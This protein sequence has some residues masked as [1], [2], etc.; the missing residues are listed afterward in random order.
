MQNNM[1]K[2]WQ[3]ASWLLCIKI[4]NFDSANYNKIIVVTVLGAQLLL[5]SLDYGYCVYKQKIKIYCS[6]P[7]IW[8]SKRNI[9]LGVGREILL[10]PYTLQVSTLLSVVGNFTQG[11]P[12]IT[13]SSK[14]YYSVLWVL[15]LPLI[16]K[17]LI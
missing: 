16:L 8:A 3:W 14:P 13:T 15:N 7:K 6:P 9:Y 12:Q 17:F 4:E 1:R 2:N 5:W 10:I 11:K